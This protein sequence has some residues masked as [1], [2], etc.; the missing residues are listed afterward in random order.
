MANNDPPF[1]RDVT[2]AVAAAALGAVAIGFF[3]YKHY[4]IVP[5]AAGAA[6]GAVVGGNLAA[7]ALTSG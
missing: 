3:A 6:L 7:R 5:A 2:I 1:E 4:G